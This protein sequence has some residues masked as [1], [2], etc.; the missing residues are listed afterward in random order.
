MN[1]KPQLVY[2]SQNM[3][4]DIK[5]F[6]F[7]NFKYLFNYLEVII[8]TVSRQWTLKNK[9]AFICR[10]SSLITHLL[11]NVYCCNINSAA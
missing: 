10:V 9:L 6:M 2:S 1:D 11:F 8:N 5:L 4:H 7:L 3:S